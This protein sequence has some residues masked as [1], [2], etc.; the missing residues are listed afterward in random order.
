[1]HKAGAAHTAPASEWATDGRDFLLVWVDGRSGRSAVYATR[2]AADG[3]VLDPDGILV[4]DA[5][6]RADAPAVAWTGDSYI[7]VWQQNG[8]RFRR[9]ARDGRIEA[10]TG[11]VLEGGCWSPRVAALNG[12]IF[13][14]ALHPYSGIEVGVIESTGAVRTL[15]S[16]IGR[17]FD[18]A[19]TRS[20]CRLVWES[21]GAVTS[22]VVSESSS[23]DSE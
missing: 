10:G 11:S 23:R 1:L 12:A 20:E 9:I 2:V 6:E 13:V 21:L 22:H 14:A 16:A 5:A 15:D 4:S 3:S 19:C 18:I 17:P 8:C 7:V